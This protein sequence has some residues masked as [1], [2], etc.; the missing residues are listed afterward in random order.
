MDVVG[1]GGNN[2]A[3][4]PYYPAAY[5]SVLDVGAGDAGSGG[6]G[7]LCT[8]S[9][10]SALAVVAPGCDSVTGGLDEVFQDDGSPAL[11]FGTSQAAAQIS[12]V[13]AAMRAYEPSLTDTQAEACLKDNEGS[14]GNLDAAAAFNACG[15]RRIV[16]AGLAAVPAPA[17]PPTDA[18]ATDS[19][20]PSNAMPRPT[21]QGTPHDL[22]VPHL[23][24][25][26]V[27]PGEL[28]VEI[29]NRPHLAATELRILGRHRRRLV[30]LAHRRSIATSVTFRIR[31]ATAVEARFIMR[32]RPITVSRWI[33]QAIL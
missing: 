23:R 6:T 33:T 1:A 21:V 4:G 20:P 8:F 31:S 7:A 29:T 30:V 22:R 10:H 28:K 14:G 27:G 12:S 13:L 9:T 24:L 5:P 16:E 18:A 32:G 17:N 11:G 25:V 2:G 26:R 19:S 15:L 3:K